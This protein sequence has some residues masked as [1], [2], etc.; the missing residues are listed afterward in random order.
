MTMQL[1]SSEE[2]AHAMAKSYAR[3]VQ[4]ESDPPSALENHPGVQRYFAEAH[5][6]YQS[7]E[8]EAENDQAGGRGSEMVKED[9]P[10][11]ELKPDP[12]LA[13]GQDRETFNEKWS[14][15]QDAAR[16]AYL[17]RYERRLEESSI[18]FENSQ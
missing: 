1:S 18:D 4:L 3:D 7:L 6:D 8:L 17:D 16:Q 14:A 10:E 2:G 15:E 12:E 5:R 9:R 11:P 13:Q